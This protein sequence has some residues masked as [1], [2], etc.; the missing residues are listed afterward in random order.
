ML[1]KVK[2]WGA[3]ILYP[4]GQRHCDVIMFDSTCDEAHISVLC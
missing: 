2:W 4:E 1:N 3:D